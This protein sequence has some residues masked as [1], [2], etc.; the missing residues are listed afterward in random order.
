M[1]KLLLLVGLV[2]LMKHNDGT[3]YKLVCY[4]TNWAHSR[5][6]PA[7][8][9]P[10]DLD[11]FLCTHL[12]FAFASMSS[13]H[14]VAN[15]LQD[16]KVLYPELNKLKERNR[17][18]KTLLSVGGWNFGTSRF[19][20]MLSTIASREEFIDSVISFLRTYGFDGLDLFFL[21][22][23]LRG[24]PVNDRWNFLLLI[25]ELQFAFEKEAL[26]TQRP[27]L[28]LSAA[29]SGVPYIIQ[30]SY[31]VRFLGR[32]LDFISVL[33][34]DLHGS[35]EKFTGHNSPLF[36]LPEDSKS[37]AYAMNYWR[38][39]GA[40][41]DKLLMGFPTYGRTFHLLSASKN[42]LKAASTGP[43]SPGKYTK[44]AGF[45]AYYE[46]CS[47]IQSAEKH[48]IDYQY[49]PYAYQGKEWVGYDDATSFSYKAMFVKKEHFGGAM[50]WTLDMD[51]VRGIF[52]G[53]GPFPLVHILNELL[54]QAGFSSTPLPQFW[55]TS[56]VNSSGPG[57]ESLTVTE[58]LT[59][60]AVKILPPGGEAMAAEV[61]GKYENVTTIPHGGFVTPRRTMSPATHTVALESNTMAPGANTTTSL[62][63]LS[64]T[65]TEMTMRVQTQT[66][67]EETTATVGNQSVT[68]GGETTATVGNQ[69]VTPGGETTATVGNQSVTPGGET[70][71]T[72]GNQ[73]VTPGGETTATVG[74][75]SVTPGGE[76]TATVGNQ[77]V[78]PGGETT[79]TVGNQSVT[80]GGETT[81]TVGNQSQTSGGETTATVGNQSVTPGGETTATV[82]NQSVTPGGETTATVGNQS[83]T[84]GGEI[85]VIVGNQSVTLGGETTAT[86]GNQSVTLGGETTATVGN[87]SVTL[88]GETT[89]TVGNQSVTP[90]GE[91]TV[92]VGNQSVTPGGETMVTVGNQS[93]TP[94][95]ETTATVGNQS[96]TLGGETTATVGNQSV[97][98]G[99]ETTATVGNQSVTLAGETTATVGNQSVTLGGE[100]TATVGNQSQTSGGEITATVGSQSVTLVGETTV[101]VGNQSVTPGGE[102]T[103]TVGN[104]SVT[105]GG[106]TTA[107]VG[108]QSVTP[109]G[110]TTAT[111]GNQSVTP[112]GETT[113]TVGNQSVTPGGE[114]TATVGNQS[115]TTVE[116][117]TTLEYL[118]TMTSSDDETSRK[119]TMTL[120][121][122]AVPPGEMS[123]T[124]N[125]QNTALMWENL[126]TEMETYSQD[127]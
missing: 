36:S 80:L 42:G 98:L 122:V 57:S 9:L 28:L 75:Q 55:V 8:I 61:H 15:S 10:R 78:T 127:G 105:L 81:A 27:R 70:T 20:S 37:S 39:L 16:E 54:V 72:V 106:E 14:I 59:T 60:D 96:V 24:S 115:V 7:S 113:A 52:C 89:A 3:A 50:V 97:T 41:A 68:P 93:V 30:R 88:G 77:S 33:S 40:P 86:V 101:T 91:I 104:Q 83:V 18:L 87:Q 76:I 49:V 19:T 67:W 53:N 79:A 125:Q 25:E 74:N 116:M 12:I 108:N 32:R 124:P 107:T 71:A 119:K 11:P 43:A 90:G 84:P 85:T 31:D 62:D 44:Q 102:T 35:W 123:V 2:L 69:S 99:G 109:G 82:G 95:E 21:Y 110:K 4:F 111:V 47:F 120:E 126:I 65:I 63:L 94:G 23:G 17:A 13:N 56:P 114:T 73:S 92:I 112:G 121:R 46:V 64:E 6:G 58:E 66:P 1:G 51:D 118:Q 100:T 45:L 5:P 38:N 22:P 48:W 26:L 117:G 29:V 34:Y 103:A